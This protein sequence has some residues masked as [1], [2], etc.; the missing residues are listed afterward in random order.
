M[1][2][3]NNQSPILLY[4]RQVTRSI[5]VISI[6]ETENNNNYIVKFEATIENTKEENTKKK[7]K[8]FW[9]ANI[10]F[11]IPGNIVKT[12]KGDKVNFKVTDYN[13]R[14]IK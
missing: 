1:S 12:P 8:T 2:L 4:K 5:K 11:Y 3:E 14:I 13:V 10:I 9:Q 7:L 6:E